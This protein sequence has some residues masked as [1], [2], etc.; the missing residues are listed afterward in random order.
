MLKPEPSG[1]A[2]ID[3]DL[4]ARGQTVVIRAFAVQVGCVPGDEVQLEKV[5]VRDKVRA[6]F[7]PEPEMSVA[8]SRERFV[9]AAAFNPCE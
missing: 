1:A 4:G 8:K 7:V 2:G 9:F 6:L 3:P 5:V